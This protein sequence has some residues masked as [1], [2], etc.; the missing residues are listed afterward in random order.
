M[1]QLLRELTLDGDELFVERDVSE[2]TSESSSE[3]IYESS[4]S[5]YC[6]ADDDGD[7]DLALLRPGLLT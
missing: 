5:E 3:S 6:E 4:S 2:G 1:Q 7:I